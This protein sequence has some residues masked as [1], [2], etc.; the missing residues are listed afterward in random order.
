MESA[1]QQSGLR[2]NSAAISRPDKSKYLYG[3]IVDF[4]VLGGASFFLLPLLFALPHQRMIGAVSFI[5]L[6]LANVINHPHFAHSYQIFYRQFAA[7]VG[8]SNLSALM[9]GRYLFAGVI[10]PILLVSYLAV[11]ITS[12]NLAWV[13]M[14]GNIMALFVGW[15]YVKQGYGMLMVDA[16]LK[17]NFFSDVEKKVLLANSYAVWTSAWL[18]FNQAK[19]Q[20][21]LW[22]VTY[23]SFDFPAEVLWLAGLVVATTTL[24]FAH[25]LWQR[26]TSGKGLPLNGCIAYFVSLYLWLLFIRIEPLWALV[27]P[28]LHSLQYMAVVYRFQLNRERSRTAPLPPAANP[29][30]GEIA[31]SSHAFRLTLFILAGMAIGIALFWQLPGWLDAT[32][33]Y[34]RQLFGANLFLFSFWIVVNVHHYFIDN[35]IWRR[36]NP[37][38]KLYLFE[39]GRPR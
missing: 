29:S 23:H 31:R 26:T 19:S 8:D 35:V 20:S 37:E 30:L 17:R 22:G 27:V 11:G 28:A 10:I 36:E 12:G 39:T 25:L 32:V 5:T 6:A 9:R 1:L 34:D 21:R 15:H 4:L 3:P 18:Y 7:R 13:A 2:A 33:A 24:L 16:A 14:A 38:A